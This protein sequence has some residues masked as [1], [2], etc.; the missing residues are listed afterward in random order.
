MSQ[1]K[2]QITCRKCNAPIGTIV[3]GELWIVGNLVLS[4]AHGI[5]AQCGYGFHYTVK[6]Q[7]LREILNTPSYN[8][9]KGA[10]PQ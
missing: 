1:D 7:L 8:H 2:K 4:E 5:C 6:T 3:K 9:L 10:N